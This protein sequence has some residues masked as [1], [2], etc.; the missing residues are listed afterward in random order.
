MSEQDQSIYKQMIDTLGESENMTPKQVKILEA[1]IEII[2]EKGYYNTS[3]SEIAKRAG[4]AEGTIFRHYR[5]KKD[6][7]ASIITPVITKFSAPFFAEKFVDQVFRKPH[8]NF[9][10]FLY[11]FI[12]NRFEFAKANVPLVKILLQE[13]A[14]HPEIQ[15][16]YK[17]VFAEKIYPAINNVL[18]YYKEKGEIKDQ[19]NLSIIRLLA[20]T[21]LGFLITRFLLQPDLEW[22]DDRE[23]RRTVDF[24]MKGIGKVGE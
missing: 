19:P 21:V 6:L 2:S 11:A 15:A 18:D 20:P 16:S 4:V 12:K 13:L 17:K 22:D 14:F 7:L 23:I 8:K 3:T 1:A 9:E 5:T 24:I 10:D